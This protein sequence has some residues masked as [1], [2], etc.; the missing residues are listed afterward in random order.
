MLRVLKK[1]LSLK[2]LSEMFV[3]QLQ[4]QNSNYFVALYFIYS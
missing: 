2:I 1:L 4:A 3:A